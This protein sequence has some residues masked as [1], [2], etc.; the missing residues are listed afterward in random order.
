MAGAVSREL[1]RETIS[2]L[3]RVSGAGKVLS[4]IH[5]ILAEGSEDSNPSIA[6]C[7]V[8][9]VRSGGFML[10][11]PNSPEVQDFL[12]S[13]DAGTE[14][15]PE[16]HPG[17]VSVLSNRGRALGEAEVMLVD[18]PWDFAG[19]FVKPVNLRSAAYRNCEVTQVEINGTAGRP[20]KESVFQLA[21]I[22][23]NS[24]I[25]DQ[26]SAAEYGSAEEFVE[27]P[28]TSGQAGEAEAEDL[29]SVD[30]APLSS[31]QLLLARI[32]ELEGRLKAVQNQPSPKAPLLPG[33]TPKAPPMFGVQQS[34]LSS[35]QWAKIQ[36]LAGSPPPRVGNLETRR[37]SL[38]TRTVADDSALI[39]HERE[40]EED[41]LPLALTNP[42]MEALDPM[43]KMLDMQL[44]QNQLLL[45][46]LLPKSQD[47]VLGAL[48]GS[49]SGSGGSSNI[50]GCLAR[51]AFQ[52]AIGDL[53]K[54]AMQARANA[55]RELGL[56]PA[57]E[58]ASL[59]RKYVERRI[60]LAEFKTLAMVATMLAE[61]W[62]VGFE[63]QDQAL[64][65]TVARMLFFVEQCA[66]DGGKTQLAWL[67]TG[68]TE[69][70]MHM[71]LT[72][73]KRPGL[74]PFSRLCP[75]SWVSANVSYLRDLDYM[76]TRLANVGKPGKLSKAHVSE[77]EKD[78]KPR[79]PNPKAKGRGKG[80]Q[81]QSAAQGNDS[82]Q[83]AG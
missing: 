10:S 54:V 21:D 62:A 9:Q 6:V 38:P 4:V 11:I 1:D 44:Q 34:P 23:I 77:D 3:A 58:D 47:P 8:V 26:T 15:L 71:M 27:A 82:T 42:E 45:Q 29:G 75:P 33:P 2:T 59:M 24:G 76:E 63:L 22:W 70:A 28:E 7:H 80:K 66:I 25:M 5:L 37:V 52:R 49:D 83:A 60:P 43:Q 30:G 79:K 12:L 68:Y 40:A 74:E 36:K 39:L 69:P 46:R 17:T 55:L 32:A 48:S 20:S 13:I 78:D 73:K 19:H 72:A 31:E 65:G 57:R 14:V 16:F 53:P 67:L 81:N 56:S 50:K 64:M 18:L 61:S 41:A 35:S 51:E